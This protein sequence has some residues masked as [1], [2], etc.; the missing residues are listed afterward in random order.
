MKIL[1]TDLNSKTMYKSI[2]TAG[3]FLSLAAGNAGAQAVDV[4]WDNNGTGAPTSGTWDNVTSNWALS[5][6]LTASTVAFTN[7]NFP[8][9]PGGS[10]SISALTITVSTNVTCAGM[11]TGIA[12]VPV[13]TNTTFSGSGS[14]GILTNG[15]ALV[16]GGYLQGFFCG[17]SGVSGNFIFD[18]PLTGPGGLEQEGNGYIYLYATNTYS[19]GTEITGGQIT[20]YNNNNSFGTGPITYAG[21]QSSLNTAAGLV[22]LTNAFII[23]SPTV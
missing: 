1:R 16:N 20:Y 6:A 12:G 8:E 22:T 23:N 14:I 5:S 11:A 2:L 15:G 4:W 9:F 10:T 18:V 3:L 19:G 17:E 21:T 13:V 7:G